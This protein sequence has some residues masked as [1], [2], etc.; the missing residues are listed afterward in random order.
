MK[1][2]DLDEEGYPISNGLRLSDEKFLKE[3]FSNL[4]RL[5]EG[6]ALSPIVSQFN[7]EQLFIHPFSEALIA[8]S[9][10]RVTAKTSVWNFPGDLSLTVD[11]N[12]LYVD[13]WKRILSFFQNENQIPGLLSPKAQAAF[14]ERVDVSELKLSPHPSSD[15]D[16]ENAKRWSQKYLDQETGWELGKTNPIFP[17]LE[18]PWSDSNEIKILVPGAGRGHDA[19]FFESKGYQVEALDFSPQAKSE[20][21]R[22]YPESKVKYHC[23]DLF[24]FLKSSP[25]SFD[26]I[27]EHTIFCAIDPKRRKEYIER[28]FQAIKP[29]GFYLGAF[30]VRSA[31]GGPPFGCTQWEIRERLSPYFDFKFWEIS[32][33]SIKVRQH[34]ELAFIAKKRT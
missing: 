17:E 18:L 1:V 33:Y 31:V 14:L 9:V 25:E 13:E 26:G 27:L 22:L 10:D 2:L 16:V 21:H 32:P 15:A 3:I 19:Q 6:E 34:K 8:Q 5:I 20:F 12:N 23:E 4:T 11:H 7:H 28:I 29:G 24:K 30:L